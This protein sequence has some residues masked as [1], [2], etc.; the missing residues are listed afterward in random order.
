M[1]Q[2][3]QTEL[4]KRSNKRVEEATERAAKLEKEAAD[5]RERTAKLEKITEWR[6]L[7][8]E[9]ASILLSNFAELNRSVALDITVEYQNG[10][11]EAFFFSNR[12]LETFAIAGITKLRTTANMMMGGAF[13]V[14]VTVC[15]EIG[16]P[17]VQQAFDEA[18]ISAIVRN[19]DLSLHFSRDVP[20]PNIFIFV[21]S[22]PPPHIMIMDNTQTASPQTR[23]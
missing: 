9:N 15:P 19:G 18:Q 8:A 20:A 21:A 3:I 22:K 2:Q 5:A 17:A 6:R 1:G 10:D 4:R 23:E 12:L 7:S 16:F 13:G 11:P 14:L